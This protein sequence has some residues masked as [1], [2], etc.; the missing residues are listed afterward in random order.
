MTRTIGYLRVSTNDQD[1]DKNK[2]EI[3]TLANNLR[4]GNVD[5]VEE[6]VSGVKDWRK[7]KFGEVFYS[8]SKGDAV[9]VSELSRLGRST[10]QILEIM[11]EAKELGIAVHAVKG[12]WSL[13]GSMES[14]IVLT[15][16]AM[17]AEIERDLISERTKEG[18]RARKAAGVK[19]G[20]PRGP[21]KSKLDQ[22]REEILVLLKNGS[23]KTYISKRYGTSV[24]NLHGWLK[25]HDISVNS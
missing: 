10:L 25:R 17:I 24:G 3:L 14:K 1:L 16:F 13:N 6:K 7:R 9:I 21:G 2:A 12:G 18:L 4:L 8:L 11:R 22:Y 5:W 15:I 23:T 19:L 20:R